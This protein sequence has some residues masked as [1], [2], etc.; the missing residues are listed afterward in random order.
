MVGVPLSGGRGCNR[1]KVELQRR[2]AREWQ[3]QRK[4]PSQFFSEM[5]M[6]MALLAPIHL[7]WK[8][9]LLENTLVYRVWQAPFA[10]QKLRPFFRHNDVPSLRGVLDVGCGPGT[11][12][13]HFLHTRYLGLDINPA[14]IAYAA[15]RYGKDF[16][17]ADIT[18]F[19]APPGQ[20]FDCILLN[21][22]LHH[23][24]DADV[25]RLLAHLSTL[26]TADGHVHIL[27]L[28][29]PPNA[30]VA[31]F[32]ARRDRG[33]FPRPLEQWRAMFNRHFEEVVFEPYPLRLLGTPPV[34]WN[35]IYFKG[36]TRQA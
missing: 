35:M 5:S 13:H 17:V 10:D 9:R 1:L 29:L 15:Q 14:Y 26:L 2:L 27:D 7:D 18:T 3:L 32:L 12:T 6:R 28:V 19:T 31:R 23:I 30:C 25:E 11:N 34:L 33:E 24:S 21:S 22:F 20:A 8:S 16:Q 4:R 36:K